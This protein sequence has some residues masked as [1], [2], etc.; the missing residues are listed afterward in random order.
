M[1]KVM[2]FGTFDGLHEGHRAFLEEARAEGDYLI[3][4]VAQDHIV[5][6]L[7]GH[8]PKLN[9]ASRFEAL[10]KEDGVDEVVAGDTHLGVW[11]VVKNYKPDV[12]AVGYDQ[13]ALKEDLKNH[14]DELGYKPEI[15][16]MRAY[17]ENK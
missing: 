17:E 4:V 16:V 10:N 5:E 2:V 13:N 3:A 12:I 6:R 1:K 7:K 14:L 9:L 15:K 11:E 8:L